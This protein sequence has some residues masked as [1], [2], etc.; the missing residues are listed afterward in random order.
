M[1]MFCLRQN[2]DP[3]I[4]RDDHCRCGEVLNLELSATGRKV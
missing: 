1:F 2:K 3:V 4:D